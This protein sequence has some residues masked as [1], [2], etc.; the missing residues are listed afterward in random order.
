M[1]VWADKEKF[2]RWRSFYPCLRFAYEENAW[3]WWWC[4]STVRSSP[5]WPFLFYRGY[6]YRQGSRFFRVSSQVASLRLLIQSCLR[7][8]LLRLHLLLLLGKRYCPSEDP[9]VP[10]SS[11]DLVFPLSDSYDDP[12]PGLRGSMTSPDGKSG[13]RCAFP[14]TCRLVQH[15]GWSWC[16]PSGRPLPARPASRSGSRGVRPHVAQHSCGHPS[17]SHPWPSLLFPSLAF[18]AI[19]KPPFTIAAQ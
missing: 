18:R 12:W 7:L 14:W 11:R 19:W 6:P 8:P 16:P 2:F 15:W 5:E 9:P 13:R 10:G 3:G 1:I 17:Y 4:G